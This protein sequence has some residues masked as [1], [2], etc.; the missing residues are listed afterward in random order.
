M[1]TEYV[2][3]EE[4]ATVKEAVMDLMQVCTQ[5]VVNRGQ[6]HNQELGAPQAPREGRLRTPAARSENRCRSLTTSTT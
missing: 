1:A 3:R 4:L 6:V 2:T 5:L